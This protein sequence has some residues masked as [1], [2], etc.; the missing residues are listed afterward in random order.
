MTLVYGVG[1]TTFTTPSILV[2]N[3]FQ[4]LIWLTS[5]II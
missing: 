4:I 1:N 3:P 5:F 2:F